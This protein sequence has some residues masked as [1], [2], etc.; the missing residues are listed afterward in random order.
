MI[1]ADILNLARR[2]LTPKQYEAWDL[3]E[4]HKLGY[5]RIALKLDIS[6]SSARDRIHR[7]LRILERHLETAA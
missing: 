3:W 7:A 2:E 6:T 1:D 5:G 4:N